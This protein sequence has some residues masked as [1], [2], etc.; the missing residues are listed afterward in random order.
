MSIFLQYFSFFLLLG[1]Y[2]NAHDV[3]FSMYSELKTQNIKIPSEMATNLM[4]LHSYILVKVTHVEHVVVFSRWKHLHD[5]HMTR[6]CL[7]LLLVN[8]SGRG[9]AQCVSIT[10]APG[11][12]GRRKFFNVLLLQ[13]SWSKR[14]YR[15]CP[16]QQ[17]IMSQNCCWTLLH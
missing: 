11:R 16:A 7:V 9:D 15:D 10:F 8:C 4:I 2:R 13:S 3:L 14:G 5:V 17:Q 1:N 12:L 6:L